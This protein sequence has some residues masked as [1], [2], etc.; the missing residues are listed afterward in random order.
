MNKGRHFSIG[1]FTLFSIKTAHATP[2]SHY[3]WRWPRNPV[4]HSI[5]Q[6]SLP[7]RKPN[8]IFPKTW[9]R[10]ILSFTL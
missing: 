4:H 9:N 6:R 10:S 1:D 8:F 5:P 2:G 3:R 7:S